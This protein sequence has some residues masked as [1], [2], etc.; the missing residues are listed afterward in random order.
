MKTF[1][2][3]L[4]GKVIFHLIS[5]VDV[6]QAVFKWQSKKRT[7]NP[8]EMSALL[9]IFGESIPYSKIR[10]LDGNKGILTPGRGSSAFVI[11]HN[12][13]AT[14]PSLATIV[15]ECVHVW[16]FEHGGAHYIGQSAFYQLRQMLGGSDPYDWQSS[17]GPEDNAWVRL[18]S[19]EAQA[20]FIED[21]YR[22]T[23][24]AFFQQTRDA[25]CEFHFGT[26]S[27]DYTSRAKAAWDI[28]RGKFYHF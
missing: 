12:I 16:Q 18:D 15:H 23:G 6:V 27:V 11:G 22:L 13:Y 7:L 5:I 3:T 1:Y 19:V 20:R 25:K 24:G 17:I 2:A 26:P 9:P 14:N 8:Q 10:I 28:I 4:A 21:V